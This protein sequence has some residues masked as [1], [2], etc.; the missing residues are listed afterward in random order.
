MPERQALRCADEPAIVVE[1]RRNRDIGLL[2]RVEPRV[3]LDQAGERAGIA[4]LP[5]IDLRE[6]RN[7][8][9]IGARDQPALGIVNHA[10]TI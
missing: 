1:I 7:R 9:R 10:A 4:R 6:R 5:R 2:R 3:L 8:E